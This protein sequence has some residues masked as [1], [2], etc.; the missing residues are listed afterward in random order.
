MDEFSC[1][2]I[3]D[4]ME[5]KK[6]VLLNLTKRQLVCFGVAAILGLP[7]YWY[8]KS[9]VGTQLASIILILISAPPIFLAIYHKNGMP[10][11]KYLFY[12]IRQKFLLPKVRPYQSDSI[13]SRLE[14]ENV[15]RKEMYAIERSIAKKGRSK[16]KK[17]AK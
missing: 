15:L 2:V 13:Y 4:F 10:A 8:S 5:V 3:M 12:V 9:I 7:A 14:R 6:T 16:K 17:A 11:E 1:P